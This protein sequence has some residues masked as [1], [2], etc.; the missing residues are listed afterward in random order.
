MPNFFFSRSDKVFSLR[1]SRNF[2]DCY[3]MEPA[4][5]Q[6][7][8]LRLSELRCLNLHILEAHR[9]RLSVPNPYFI[10]S[11]NQVKVGRRASRSYQIPS[12]TR[13]LCWKKRGKGSEVT[14]LIVDLCGLKNGQ[15]TGDWYPLIGM[16]P[17]GEWGSILCLYDIWTIWSCRTSVCQAE[18][19]RENETHFRGASLATILMDLYMRAEFFC[20]RLCPTQS[21]EY[22]KTIFTSPDA[23]SRTVRFICNC[24]Q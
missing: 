3:E 4:S 8:V 9:C 7:K 17:M 11:L 19:A 18:V 16:D 6:S 21:K 2:F 22:S 24:L 5:A 15:E 13:S 12:G 1:F 23:C 20:S 10:V 14:E